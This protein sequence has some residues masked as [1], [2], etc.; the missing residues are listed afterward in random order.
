M[1]R[2]ENL[3]T[4]R[5]DPSKKRSFK[6]KGETYKGLEAIRWLQR[7]TLIMSEFTPEV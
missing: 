3:P 6:Y 5:I 1:K 2:L 7:Y 4:L